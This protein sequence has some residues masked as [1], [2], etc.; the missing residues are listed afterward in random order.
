MNPLTAMT[1]EE[2]N[3]KLTL[4]DAAKILK[5]IGALGIVEKGDKV[6]CSCPYALVSPRYHKRKA[7]NPHA[8]FDPSFQVELG[9]D[10][11]PMCW[12]WTCNQPTNGPKDKIPIDEL[13]LRLKYLAELYPS[14][15][16]D[17]LI[18]N[19]DATFSALCRQDF[20][21]GN[22]LSVSKTWGVAAA[23]DPYEVKTYTPLPESSL[24][25]YKSVEQFPEA[26][27]CILNRGAT[28]ESAIALDMRYD[29]KR[30]M[31]ILPVR[32]R[33]TGNISGL[34][35]RAIAYKGNHFFYENGKEG[36][37]KHHIYKYYHNGGGEGDDGDEGGTDVWLNE[38]N[39]DLS[40]PIVVVEGYPSGRRHL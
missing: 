28:L 4:S 18:A 33:F 26:V 19:C 14:D 39:L 32:D 8:D 29:T 24:E 6:I 36:W 10:G 21:E 7:H 11:D 25:G 9:K 13:P 27:Q 5:G 16:S 40:A 1:V 35:G 31:V 38:H 22:F 23:L 34:R 3:P 12:C 2:T 30:K 15:H 37:Q 17:A 20:S